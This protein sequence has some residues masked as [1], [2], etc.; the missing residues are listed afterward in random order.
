MRFWSSVK[1]KSS[2]EQHHYILSTPKAKDISLLLFGIFYL[3]IFFIAAQSHTSH[4]IWFW[5][6]VGQAF[7]FGGKMYFETQR[8]GN[9]AQAKPMSAKQYYWAVH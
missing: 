2:S 7:L 4:I 8:R 1:K 3:F 5:C 6:L 9:L